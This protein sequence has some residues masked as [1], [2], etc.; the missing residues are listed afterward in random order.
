MGIQLR[1]TD[2]VETIYLNRAGDGP[3]TPPDY[4]PVAL[5]LGADEGVRASVTEAC[6]V[7]FGGG[8]AAGRIALA[9][10]ERLLG[11]AAHRHVT[12]RGPTVWLE[13]DPLGDGDYWRSEVLEGSATTDPRGLSAYWQGRGVLHA[14]LTWRRRAWWD[15]AEREIGLSVGGGAPPNGAYQTGGVLVSGCGGDGRVNGWDAD[16]AALA[17]G[18][19]DVATL[20]SPARLS[21]TNNGLAE[22]GR[23]WIGQNASN[24][25]ADFAAWLEGET[26]QDGVTYPSPASPVYSGGFY[27][28]FIWTSANAVR[29]GRWALDA[30]CLDAGHG[31]RFRLLGRLLNLPVN[32]R[33]WAGLGCAGAPAWTGPEVGPEAGHEIQDLGS[34]PLPP[35]D[36][37]AG[38]SALDLELWARCPDGI[39]RMVDV[40]WWQITPLDGLR[41]YLPLPSAI[42]DAG[43]TLIDDGAAGVVYV[44]AGAAARPGYVAAGEPLALW[45]NTAQRFY[46]LTED[47]AG[48]AAAPGP[49]VTVRMWGRPRRASF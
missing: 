5:E 33:V 19:V 41:R 43:Q 35:L 14:A 27:Q 36:Y 1:L 22:I 34:L 48:A 44:Q 42:L 47:A 21:V 23:L 4:A 30:A 10:I 2:G 49:S 18:G 37:G 16:P 46:L 31:N 38:A 45:P 11:Q 17:D 26:C 15:G 20:P 12:G 3:D 40:D 28:R 24:A 9:A 8:A 13:L 6:R 29:L 25:P 32:T 39:A 7:S